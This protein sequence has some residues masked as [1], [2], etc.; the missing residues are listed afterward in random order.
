MRFRIGLA[1]GL[2]VGYYLGTGADPERRRQLNNLFS[3]LQRSGSMESATVK[4]RAVVDLGVERARDIVESHLPD[5]A[6]AK[7]ALP[8]SSSR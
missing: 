7:D 4:A 8:Y 6:T 3:R 2:A 1:L 5:L